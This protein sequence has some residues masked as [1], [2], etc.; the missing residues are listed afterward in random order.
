MMSSGSIDSLSA[1]SLHLSPQERGEGAQS[2]RGRNSSSHGA[3][4]EWQDL[5]SEFLHAAEDFVDRR[6][7][8]AEIDAAD[9]EVAE[10]P[11]VGGEQRRRTGEQPMF[12]I[13]GL[14]RRG[15]AEHRDAQA[16]ADRLWI[17]P[18]FNSQ[19]AQAV[20]LG[21]QSREAIERVL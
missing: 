11:D 7:A 8:E 2:S 20:H 12:A 4:D 18:G 19:F 6:P 21:L 13:T 17:A 10:R 15:R 5:G 16:Q 14:R 3:L 1:G 9:A